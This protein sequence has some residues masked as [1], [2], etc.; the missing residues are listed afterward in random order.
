MKT[1][2]LIFVSIFALSGCAG[3][4]LQAYD[5][6]GNVLAEYV[7]KDAGHKNCPNQALDIQRS[8]HYR[9]GCVDER[10]PNLNYS[11]TA[12]SKHG[13]HDGYLPSSEYT[14]KFNSPLSCKTVLRSMKRD[15][16]IKILNVR[17]D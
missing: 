7:P 1:P 10:A 13:I 14:I 5:R 4:V 16:S 12:I 3:S 15:D 11:V 9:T 2:A 8:W 17:C 6:H